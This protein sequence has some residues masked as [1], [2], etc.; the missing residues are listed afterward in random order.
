[1][2]NEKVFRHVVKAAFAQRR[3]TLRNALKGRFTAHDFAQLGI[4]G[5]LRAQDLGV[6]DF[7]RLSDAVVGAL[8]PASVAIP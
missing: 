2:Q 6:A 8:S 3:K 1:M 5:G 7:V 4:D